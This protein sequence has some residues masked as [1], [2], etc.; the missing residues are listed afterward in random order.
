MKLVAVADTHLFHDDFVIPEGDTFIHAGDL[1]RRGTLDELAIACAWIRGLPHT[2]KVVVAGN[3]DWAFVRTPNEARSMLRDAG[4]IYLEDSGAVID[5]LRFWGS[6]WQPAYNDWAFNLPRGAALA[7]K[8]SLIPDGIDVL[9]THCPPAGIGD[10]TEMAG[11]QGCADLLARVKTVKP[12]L[13]LFGHIH[14]DGG[15]WTI[16]GTRFANV[17]S[18]ECQRAPTVIEIAHDRIAL[19]TIPPR[20]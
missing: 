8:W 18:W 13:Q 10:D 14:N 7:G 16:G 15:A 1:C 17:T 12:R 5:G 20:G 11:R 9:V 19:T 6:P 2:N 3:H 4:A